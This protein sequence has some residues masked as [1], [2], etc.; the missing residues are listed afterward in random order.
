MPNTIVD[1]IVHDETDEGVDERDFGFA[2]GQHCQC[3]EPNAEKEE[4]KV[5]VVHVEF[6]AN[7]VDVATW[8]GQ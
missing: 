6:S 2:N 7:K 1:H 3:T 8:F 4:I 5:H